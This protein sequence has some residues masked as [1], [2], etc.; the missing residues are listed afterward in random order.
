MNMRRVFYAISMAT[1]ILLATGCEAINEE[2]PSYEETSIVTC[3]EQAPDFTTTLLSGES[4]TLSNLRGQVVLLIFFSHTCPDCK[5]LLDDLKAANEEME[6]LGVR[7]VAIAREGTK[8]EIEGY[9]STNGY[10]F[11]TAI[12]NNREIYNLY[13]TM[14]VPRCYLIDKEG[15]VVAT[16]VEYQPDHV[17]TLLSQI[18]TLE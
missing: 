9:L 18:E 4:I 2:L 16:T 8:N 17:P 6:A 13:A 11:D 5:A 3:Q 12:D 1:M 10:S 15:M 14:Y 7:I